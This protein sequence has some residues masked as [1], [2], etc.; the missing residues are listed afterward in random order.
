MCKTDLLEKIISI[1]SDLTE[2]EREE[3]LSRSRRSD[4]TEAK[5]LLIYLLK[6]NGVKPYK[7]ATLLNIPERSIYYAITSFSLRSDQA[8]SMLGAWL[9]EANSR[10]QKLRNNPATTSQ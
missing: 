3:L 10:L 7:I 9:K 2:I 5:C 8:G 4:V 6:V 1:V